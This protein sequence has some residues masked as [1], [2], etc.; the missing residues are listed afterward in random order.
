MKKIFAGLTAW[1]N[2]LT[3]YRKL[4]FFYAFCVILPLVVTDGIIIQIMNRNERQRQEY[5]LNNIAEVVG[6]NITNLYN[7]ILE[8]TNA[9]YLDRTVN[10]FISREYERPYDY[11]SA[12]YRL[13]RQSLAGSI[14]NNSDYG[15]TIYTDNPTIAG[16]R[17]LF[18]GF[19]PPIP[20][21]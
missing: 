12:N 11:Y 6:N 5:E 10:D 16:Y 13:L 2:N 17:G 7:D 1:M 4:I 15:V 21:T 14:F 19:Y 18:S 8:T 9:I 3:I 20:G